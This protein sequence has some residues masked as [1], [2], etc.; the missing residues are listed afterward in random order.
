ML[1]VEACMAAYAQRFNEDRER[2]AVTALLHDFDW[3]IHPAAPDHPALT[4]RFDAP[5]FRTQTIAGCLVYHCWNARFSL[6]MSW[7]DF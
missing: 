5:F 7:P 6:A 3:E 2:W 4:M 1:A